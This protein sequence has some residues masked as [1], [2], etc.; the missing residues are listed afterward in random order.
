MLRKALLS[1]LV[2]CFASFVQPVARGADAVTITEQPDSLR[3]EINGKL[4]T[5]YCFVGAPHVY[6]YPLIG[7]GGVH[8]TRHFPMKTDAPNEDRDH[9]HHRSLWFSHGAVNG[10]DFWSEGSKAGKIVHDKFLEIKSGEAVGLIRSADK[11]IAPSGEVICTDER[12]FR[13]YARPGAERVF[14]FEITL[15]APAEK[16]VVL[17]DTRDG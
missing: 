8:M 12:T 1:I 13:V 14:D 16:D 5:E 15:K 10:V 17:G 2:C 11:W 6:F 9:Q 3:I 7:P 4:F